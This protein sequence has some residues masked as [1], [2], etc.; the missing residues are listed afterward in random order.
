M[1]KGLIMLFVLAWLI[2]AG[3]AW[4]ES[5]VVVSHTLTGYNKGA[6]SVVLNYTLAIKNAG[7]SSISNLTLSYVP[8]MIVSKDQIT[9]NIG[10]LA[11]QA[12]IKVPFTITTPML[13]DQNV[14]SQQTL[15]WAGKYTD[16]NGAVIEFPAQSGQGGTL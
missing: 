5:P 3:M 4:A 8:L 2:P 9:L 10:T 11:P 6:D 15:F 14:F 7:T 16:N 12:E 13:L 1:R